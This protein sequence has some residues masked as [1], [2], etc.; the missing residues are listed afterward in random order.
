MN[1]QPNISALLIVN[2]ILHFISACM[3][4]VWISDL[5]SSSGGM[6][7]LAWLETALAV[8]AISIGLSALS[9]IAIRHIPTL[10]SSQRR[11]RQGR[12]LRWLFG[13]VLGAPAGER[14]HLEYAHQ[15]FK[16]ETQMRRTAV[17]TIENRESFLIDCE[18]VGD[19]MSNQESATGAFSREGGDVGRVAITLRNIADGCKSARNSIYANR[20]YLVRQFARAD[21]ILIDLRRVI[22]PKM[23]AARRWSMRASSLTNGSVSCAAS[24]MHSLPRR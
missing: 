22:V 10:P 12:L 14:A 15:E 4:G 2:F 7:P 6:T 8:V 16:T 20:A 9:Y 21:R 24:M 5:V 18:N 13:S 1:K 11:I 17:A 3:A 23:I 19:A